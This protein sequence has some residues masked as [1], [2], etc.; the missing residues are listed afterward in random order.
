[1]TV[2][3]SAQQVVGGVIR[4]TRGPSVDSE[5]YL[6]PDGSQTKVTFVETTTKI[7][8]NGMTLMVYTRG[9]VEH[10]EY[11]KSREDYVL[12]V[13]KAREQAEVDA[14]EALDRRL[15]EVDSRM[16]T[17]VA[18][19]SATKVVKTEAPDP[20]DN[21]ITVEECTKAPPHYDC[22]IG[23]KDEDNQPRHFTSPNALNTHKRSKSHKDI[24][25]LQGDLVE[26]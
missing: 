6:W 1:L 11:L 15:A 13:Q 5:N 22:D 4:T 14:K 16:G 9:S 19:A 12:E 3:L 17:D 20:A 7:E 2:D 25:E 21:S 26:V 8:N 23:C 18:K 10:D 24:E